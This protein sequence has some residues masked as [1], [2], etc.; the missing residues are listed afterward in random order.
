MALRIAAIVAAETLSPSQQSLLACASQRGHS[1]THWHP[2]AMQWQAGARGLSFQWQGQALPDIDLIYWW[3]PWQHRAGQALVEALTL[4]GKPV[5]PNPFMPMSDK[6]S[7]AQRLGAAG[8]PI[9]TTEIVTIRQL[10]AQADTV[11]WP[12]VIKRPQGARGNGVFWVKDA[13]D[14][15]GVIQQTG[16]QPDQLVVV[17]APVF[18]VGQPLGED[19]RAFM[20]DGAVAA[21]MQRRGNGQDFRANIALGG[22]GTVTHL[23]NE[24]NRAVLAAWSAMGGAA[25]AGVDFIRTHTGPVVLEVNLWPGFI[26]LEAT[27]GLDIASLLVASWERWHA[28]RVA[29]HG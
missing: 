5:F 21:A 19:V 10:L 20:I 29:A 18:G 27:T 1:V 11:A 4:A 9:P 8:A 16:L 13:D 12:R 23:S 7:Q 15:P 25:W 22:E 3:L 6:V 17:Q 24:E 14:L 2:D 28:A 26:G